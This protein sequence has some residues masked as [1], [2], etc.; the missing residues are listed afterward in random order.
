MVLGAPSIEGGPGSA[1]AGS[2]GHVADAASIGAFEGTLNL[3]DAPSVLS[4]TIIV[5]DG[6]I[7]PGH[8]A[9]TVG[10]ADTFLLS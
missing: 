7:N 2:V 3:M 8:E 1:D 5:R 6:W 10:K 4:T 9:A